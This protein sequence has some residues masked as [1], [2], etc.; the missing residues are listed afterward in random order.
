MH[1]RPHLP[2]PAELGEIYSKD[3]LKALFLRQAQQA[4]E[5]T[6]AATG[7][8]ADGGIKGKASDGIKPVSSRD[9]HARELT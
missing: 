5:E 3:E 7:A 4:K 2:H 6:A 1:P 9:L 8:S